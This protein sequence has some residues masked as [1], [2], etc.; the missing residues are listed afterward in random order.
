MYEE[1]LEK[2]SDA[3]IRKEF[4][5]KKF[6]KLGINNGYGTESQTTLENLK[7]NEQQFIE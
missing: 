1:K 3:N 7:I 2:M 4:W 6:M 5:R